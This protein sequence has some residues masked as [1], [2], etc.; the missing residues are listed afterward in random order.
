MRDRRSHF[1]GIVPLVAALLLCLA[2]CASPETAPEIPAPSE[3][4][5]AA[6]TPAEIPAENTE[7]TEPA[8]VPEETE[9]PEK[10]EAPEETEVPEEEDVLF[11]I[12]IGD[13][14]IAVRPEENVSAEAFL[15]L[16]EE[17]DAVVEMQD[18]GGFEKVGPLGTTLPDCDETIT[19]VP[20]DVILY[21]GDQ[22]TVYYDTNT[23]SFTRL[24]RVEG[25]DG[26]ALR[27]ILGEGGLTAVFSLRGPGGDGE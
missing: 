3:P 25:L 7:V 9:V 2:S 21:Q 13:T 17:G 5:T 22:I 18:Y 12:W 15:A 4:G 14:A 10:T 26:E 24:G 23:W 6:L 20:G 27:E 1:R 11:Y 19:T 8:A 16:L